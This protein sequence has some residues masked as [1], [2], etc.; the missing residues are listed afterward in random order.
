MFARLPS[1][2]NSGCCIDI[3][4]GVAVGPIPVELST[5]PGNITHAQAHNLFLGCA[6]L[7]IELYGPAERSFSLPSEIDGLADALG[8]D[9]HWRR[10]G[11]QF[12]ITLDYKTE[13]AAVSWGA[14]SESPE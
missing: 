9:M 1:Q 7:L 11:E 13:R 12:G 14:Q 6:E 2:P 5:Q 10:K 4:G 3:T 8:I